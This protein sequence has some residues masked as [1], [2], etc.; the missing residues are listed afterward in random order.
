MPRDI[1]TFCSKCGSRCI[2]RV[3]LVGVKPPVCHR[4]RTSRD[5]TRPTVCACCGETKPLIEFL[6]PCGEV[7]PNCRACIDSGAVRAKAAKK[8]L[9]TIKRGKQTQKPARVIDWPEIEI[10]GDQFSGEMRCVG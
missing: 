5:L 2:Q 3:E 9:E 10:P 7:N 1:R 8:R 4:C 6:D